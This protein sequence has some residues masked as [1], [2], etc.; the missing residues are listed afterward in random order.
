MPLAA[1]YSTKTMVLFEYNGPQIVLCEHGRAKRLGLFAGEDGKPGPDV[2]LFAEVSHLELE[3]LARGRLPMRSAF[4]RKD[5]LRLLEFDKSNRPTRAWTIGHESVLAGILPVTGAPLPTSSREQLMKLLKLKTDVGR[6]IRFAGAPVRENAIELAALARLTQSVQSILTTIGQSLG[7]GARLT[8]D[9]LPATALLA[10]ATS[11]G[12]FAIHVRAANSDVF[13]RVV[14]QYERLVNLAFED[15]DQLAKEVPPGS[16]L[17]KSLRSYLKVLQE[18]QAETML[19]GPE[20][21]VYVGFNGANR[22][23][24]ALKVK[25][26]PKQ[27]AALEEVSP[28]IALRGYFH[29][30][31]I[32]AATFSFFDIDDDKTTS[33][34]V[35]PLLMKRI[36][37]RALQ[38]ASVGHLTRYRAVIEQRGD[39]NVLLDFEKIGQLSLTF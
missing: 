10:D 37:E 33:G 7:L 28:Q 15:D 30:F 35:S 12:S 34:K 26:T 6:R 31:G 21:H 4:T 23:R 27:A 18:L 5:S 22:A 24:A 20:T 9:G 2:W 32:E 39:S 16:P 29:E 38:E 11:L 8:D 14:R 3:A 36:S 19:D 1:D 17:G 25:S 13:E